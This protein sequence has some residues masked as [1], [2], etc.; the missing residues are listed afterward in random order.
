[1]ASANAVCDRWLRVGARPC[2]VTC[3]FR[4]CSAR[5]AHERQRLPQGIPP[6]SSTPAPC[7]TR[8]IRCISVQAMRPTYDGTLSV[9]WQESI[10]LLLTKG[11]ILA[12][13]FYVTMIM[14]RGTKMIIFRTNRTS[15]PLQSI[16]ADH[17][18]DAFRPWSGLNRF[19]IKECD[20]SNTQW[21]LR[22]F[23]NA[24]N[25]ASSLS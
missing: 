14:L 3:F 15:S 13:F 8:R 10:L 4:S 21:L 24:Q 2:L 25:L 1:M 7:W 18:V 16:H 19:K 22:F 17:S 12:L 5:D 20:G 9:A 11:L 6:A 23:K